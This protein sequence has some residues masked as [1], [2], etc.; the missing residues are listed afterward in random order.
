MNLKKIYDSNSTRVA[1]L[2]KSLSVWEQRLAEDPSNKKLSEMISLRQSQLKELEEKGSSEPLSKKV[3]AVRSEIPPIKSSKDLY[4][5]AESLG[6]ETKNSKDKFR[7]TEDLKTDI[8][9]VLWDREFPGQ[10]M[11]PQVSP[12]LIK[13]ITS[14]GKEFVD[15]EFPSSEYVLQQK[16]NGQRFILTL[17]PSGKTYMTSRGRSVKTFRF[18]ELDDH[19]LGLLNLKSPFSGRVI[20]DG[21]IL[22]DIA[23]LDLPSG[24]HT[25]STLQSTVALMHM[26]SKDSIEYQRSHGFSLRFKVFDILMFDG[27]SVEHEPY[28]TRKELT[29]TACAKIK[30]VNPDCSIDVLPTIEDYDSAWDTFMEYVQQGGEGM[31]LKSRKAPYEQGKRTKGQWK[32]KGNLEIDCFVSGFVPSSEDKSLRNYIGGFK[33]STNYHNKEIEV[34]AVSN[35]DLATRKA[36]TSYDENGTPILNE[37]WLGKCASLICQNFKKGS[38]RMGSARI[39]EWRD[40]KTPEDCVLQDEMIIYDS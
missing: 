29:V 11:P 21:E 27:K 12:M 14:K 6:I 36:A 16:I 38:L 18:A 40:D 10:E 7:S 31:I 22:C 26:N 17:E 39:S 33:F 37:E 3:N 34:A 24:V 32:L 13:D 1:Q 2:K 9:K 5:Y 35:I 20:L 4:A 28:D 30:E 25:T 8:A 15:K 23:E 19:V